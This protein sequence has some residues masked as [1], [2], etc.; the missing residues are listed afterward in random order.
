[1]LK[2]REIVAMTAKTLQSTQTGKAGAAPNKARYR[3]RIA[4]LKQKKDKE[5]AAGVKQ[6]AH[7][8]A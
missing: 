7:S 5:P 1:M 3:N 6:S 4:E 2:R 8:R